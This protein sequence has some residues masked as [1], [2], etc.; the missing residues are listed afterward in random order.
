[1]K[2]ETFLSPAVSSTAEAAPANGTCGKYPKISKANTRFSWIL[3]WGF[4][5]KKS[6][7]YGFEWFNCSQSQEGGKNFGIPVYPCI[8]R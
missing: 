1:M 7:I 6:K 2:K 3:T 5:R 4:L 8:F